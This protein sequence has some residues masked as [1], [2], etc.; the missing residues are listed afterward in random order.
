MK[1]KKS[2]RVLLADD[3][4]PSREGTRRYLQRDADI[5]LQEAGEFKSVVSGARAFQ[6][7]VIVMD[8]LFVEHGGTDDGIELVRTLKKEVPAARTVMFTNHREL[9]YVAAA[10]KAGASGYIYKGEVELLVDAIRTVHSGGKAFG[11]FTDHV[12]GVFQNADPIKDL[13]NREREIAYILLKRGALSNEEIGEILFISKR[14]VSTHLCNMYSKLDCR[15]PDMRNA[16]ENA[17]KQK[18]VEFARAIRIMPADEDVDDTDKRLAR[19]D[20]AKRDPKV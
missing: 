15:L 7:D 9:K 17:K 6:P 16:N 18:L 19:W 8:V 3:D 12:L 5:Q 1:P 13:T 4:R 11:R 20:D 10:A 2:I 14:T